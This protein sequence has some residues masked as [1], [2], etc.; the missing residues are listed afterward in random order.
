MEPSSGEPVLWTPRGTLAVSPTAEH[1]VWEETETPSRNVLVS[2]Q[3]I[4]KESKPTP[5]QE[6]THG[7]HPVFAM[8][9]PP[10][11]E[12]AWAP[13]P[14]RWLLCTSRSTRAQLGG[15][16]V[17]LRVQRC[18]LALLLM[19]CWGFPQCGTLQLCSRPFSGHSQEAFP[20]VQPKD[21]SWW[22][23]PKRVLLDSWLFPQAGPTSPKLWFPGFPRSV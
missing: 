8:A 23:C 21:G 4:C 2:N 10:S 5:L 16:N 13:T 22:W 17:P 7:P 11:G 20:G 14:L 15:A 18:L 3:R 1:M 6:G 19:P 9:L 12:S